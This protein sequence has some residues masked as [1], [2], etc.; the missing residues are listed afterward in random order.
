[1][2]HFHDPICSTISTLHTL[3]MMSATPSVTKVT[4]HRLCFIYG[5]ELVGEIIDETL[6]E[7][8]M[9]I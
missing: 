6:Q 4:T 9:T 2:L 1:M 5:G 8:A 3:Y 7:A